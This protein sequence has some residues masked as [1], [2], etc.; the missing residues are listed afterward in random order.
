MNHRTDISEHVTDEVEDISFE[1]KGKKIGGF[2]DI[3]SEDTLDLVVVYDSSYEIARDI[4]RE[5]IKGVADA[6][7]DLADK[8]LSLK[9]CE[10]E[11]GHPHSWDNS[12]P[13]FT[14]QTT[15]PDKSHAKSDEVYARDEVEARSK[16]LKKN[17]GRIASATY[18][19]EEGDDLEETSA[20][21]TGVGAIA[22]VVG[23]RPKNPA[24]EMRKLMNFVTETVFGDNGN[25][26]TQ[27]NPRDT[28]QKP[29]MD[30]MRPNDTP[31]YS[32]QMAD[33]IAT[34]ASKQL[35]YRPRVSP[36]GTKGKFAVDANPSDRDAIIALASQFHPDQEDKQ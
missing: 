23:G 8:L 15:S 22:P 20:G 3:R 36:R 30:P 2:I 27:N 11:K 25:A 12:L 18:L 9:E 28:I 1:Y 33:Q 21:V 14:V 19:S 13:S 16:A 7:I 10:C 17:N 32:K 35:G 29:D 34:M 24:K 31:L 4:P 6:I 26:A 5:P